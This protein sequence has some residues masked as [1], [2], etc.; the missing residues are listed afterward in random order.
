M[1]TYTHNT[2]YRETDK[3]DQWVMHY[4][5]E[6]DKECYL[7]ATRSAMKAYQTDNY[8]M[9]AVIGHKNIKKYKTLAVI[10][11]EK[12]GFTF[13]EL[14]KIGVKKMMD[15]TYKDWESFMERLDYFENRKIIELNQPEPY[16]FSNLGRDIERS[17][18]ERG[19]PR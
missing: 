6:T 13:S 1:D 15:G 2:Q 9:A 18:I 5:D 16:D 14:M 11:L 3:F 19:L 8:Q 4:T 17:R 10:T 7:N 12:I